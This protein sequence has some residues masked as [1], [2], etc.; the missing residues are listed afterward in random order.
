MTPTHDHLRRLFEL[1]L[2]APPKDRP[3]LLDQHC[4]GDAALRH[5]LEAMLLAAEKPDNFLAS[6]SPS[7]SFGSSDFDAPGV[8][9]PHIST[10]KSPA[11]AE[12]P[13]TL[14]GRYKLLQKIGEGGFGAVFL[15][16]QREPVARKVALKIIKLGMDTRQVIARFEAER[17]ALALMDHPNIARVLDAGATDSGRPFFVMEYVKG[18][19]II[20]FA[21]AH[22]LS[23][24]AR[25]E[26]FTQICQAVQHAHTKGVIH[27]DLKPGN[28][29]VS[30]SDGKPFARVI[31]FGIAKATGAMGGRLTD[32]TLF[33]EHHQLIGTPE[34]MSPEQAEG[35]P[36]IDTRTDVYSLGVLLYELLT[37]ATPFDAGRLRSAAFA[38]MQRII[39]EEDPPSPSLRL[40]R[41]LKTLAAAAAARKAERGKLCPLIKGELDWIVMKALDKDRA[42]RYESPSQLAADVQRHLSGEA[43]VAAPPRTSYLIGKFVRRNKSRVAMGGMALLLV[44]SLAVVLGISERRAIVQRER[45]AQIASI[46]ELF[47]RAVGELTNE[48]ESD[49]QTYNELLDRLAAGDL[50]RAP[51]VEVAF[52]SGLALVL[53][54]AED[55]DEIDV[56][57]PAIAIAERIY[58]PGHF[59]TMQ[60][61]AAIADSYYEAEETET[62]DELYQIRAD[63][64][65]RGAPHSPVLFRALVDLSYTQV[66][67]SVEH[68]DD[69]QDVRTQDVLLECLQ[70]A[71]ELKGR[72]DHAAGSK[73]RPTMKM[74]AAK[75]NEAAVELVGEL[76]EYFQSMPDLGDGLAGASALLDALGPFE[77]KDQLGILVGAHAEAL[78]ISERWDQARPR[79]ALA[80]SRASGTDAAMDVVRYKALLARADHAR[81]QTD[82][83]A[84]ELAALIQ[85]VNANTKL[86]SDAQVAAWIKTAQDELASP[87]PPKTDDTP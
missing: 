29:L 69:E 80:V 3:A 39:R 72:D 54:N 55:G 25:L 74:D 50:S 73:R 58:G 51:E 20:A 66:D 45:V 63:Q 53:L 32:K 30:M 9:P 27:R 43:V 13:G 7:R 68:D 86:Q 21:D 49:Y 40:T 64:L 65:R 59:A 1:L 26:L 33:T 28:I 6:V 57:R 76:I 16:E 47:G 70:L 10:I 79:L 23:I 42:R 71:T 85:E 36:D 38:E 18:D 4:A 19:P 35:S 52:R 8:P 22:K 11:P 41:D 56:F 46:T 82:D 84:R 5:R 87:P 14:I 77:G 67:L 34:Y 62:A 48:D 2:D 31:D 44:L 60:T 78:F 12:T 17:Q 83:A 61:L 81:G 15:A 37:G 75:Y 24:P